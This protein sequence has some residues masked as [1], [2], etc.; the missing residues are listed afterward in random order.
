G[1]RY[2][3]IDALDVCFTDLPKLLDFIVQMSSTS[4]RVKWIMFSRS[5]LN[6]EERLE[7]AKDEVRLSLE[8]NA[9]SVST[10]V[11]FYITH[12]VSRLEREKKYSHQTKQAVL[13]YLYTN[14]N[15]TTCA[16]HDGR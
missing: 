11:Y 2:F 4:S 12:K 9:D 15:D 8:L 6:I 5:W 3:V 1:T 10:A 13:N 14:A 7:R 16:C